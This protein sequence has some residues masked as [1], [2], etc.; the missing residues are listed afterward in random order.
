[1]PVDGSLRSPGEAQVAWAWLLACCVATWGE[2]RG[3]V[4]ARA[5]PMKV[6]AGLWVYAL[7][8]VGEA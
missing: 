5:T 4:I 1:M 3:A 6:A 8:G 7:H 2:R